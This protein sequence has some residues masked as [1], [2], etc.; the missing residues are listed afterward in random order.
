[1][2]ARDILLVAKLAEVDPALLL[3]LQEHLSDYDGLL[4]H[5]FMGDVTRWA[6]Q[7]YGAD[8]S[9]PALKAVLDCLEGAFQGPY[10]EEHELIAASFLE[11]LPKEDEPNA[12]IRDAV[13]PALREHLDRHG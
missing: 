2:N 9:D 11:N 10:P 4:P 13:G 7:R 3:L 12:K 5:V 6:V 8:P 1:M